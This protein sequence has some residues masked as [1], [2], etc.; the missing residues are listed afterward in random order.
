MNIY[1]ASGNLH[2]LE[3]ISAMLAEVKSLTLRSVSELG[4]MPDVDENAPDFEGN[5]RLKAQALQELVPD[6][7]YVLADDSGLVVDALNGA[8]GVRSARYAGE[9]CSDADNNTKLL[10]AL[11]TL[12]ASQ[13]TAHFV[14]VFQLLGPEIDKTFRGECHGAI[15]HQESGDAGFGYDPL[16]TPDG[17][18]ASFASLGQKVKSQIS[19]R[20][21]AVEQ[22]LQFLKQIEKS[23]APVT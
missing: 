1:L 16:F 6:G 21:R 9:H 15:D 14:C 18:K 13:R 8:P 4:G 22:L 3:E 17:Y 10:K 2:K 5:A 11:E 20:A 7:S 23:N 12:P 19:H